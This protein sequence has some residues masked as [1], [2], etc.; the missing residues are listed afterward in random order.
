MKTNGFVM[1]MSSIA[2]AACAAGCNWIPEEENA[3][4]IFKVVGTKGAE[5]KIDDFTLKVSSDDKTYYDGRFADRPQ[6]MIVPAGDYSAKLISGEFDTPRFD[7]PQFG[8][9]LRFTLEAGQTSTV[10]LNCTLLN[11]GLKISVTNNFKAVYPVGPLIVHQEGTSI[12]YTYG[13][14]KTAY[15]HQGDAFIS[16]GGEIIAAVPLRNGVVTALELDAEKKGSTVAFLVNVGQAVIEEKTSIAVDSLPLLSVAQ[17]K[18]LPTADSLKA[19]V[20]GYIIGG[21]KNSKVVRAGSADYSISSN[22]LLADNPSDSTLS[23]CLPVELKTQALQNALSL[24]S[25]PSLAGCRVHVQGTVLTYF[26]T[27]GLKAVCDY[28]VNSQ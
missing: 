3:K 5:V 28:A 11:A 8:D 20:M 1:V 6:E 18:R 22:I 9:S 17:A 7:A 12:E 26:S 25:N 19:C 15:F 4:I 21:V 16:C 13:C 24:T 2:L 23:V 10:T 27:A 14:D